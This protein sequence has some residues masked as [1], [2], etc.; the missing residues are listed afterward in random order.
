MSDH[1][2]P[3]LEPELVRNAPALARLA[4]GLWW[5]ASKWGVATSARTAA[6]LARGAADP[7]RAARD[8]T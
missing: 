7:V 5:Q 6:R 2:Q 4:A 8:R 3:P 1:R